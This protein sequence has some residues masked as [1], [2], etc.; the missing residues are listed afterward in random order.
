MVT[1]VVWLKS[2]RQDVGD[3]KKVWPS[4]VGFD[5]SQDSFCEKPASDFYRDGWCYDSPGI[6]TALFLSAH[7]LK[8]LELIEYAIESMKAVCD[9]FEK[10]NPLECVSFVMN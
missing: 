8:D 9:R 1:I 4:R 7:A 3:F 5:P 10:Q 2:I 6:A